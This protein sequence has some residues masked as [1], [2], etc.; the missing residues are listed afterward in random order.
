M[1][2]FTY[3][4]ASHSDCRPRAGWPRQQPWLLSTQAAGTAAGGLQSPGSR[5][6]KGA[7]GRQSVLTTDLGSP[8]ATSRVSCWLH[9]SEQKEVQACR[10]RGVDGTQ[11]CFCGQVGLRKRLASRLRQPTLV[12]AAH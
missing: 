9:K 6:S 1:R 5:G 2:G 4:Q 8:S 11:L 7:R 3:C 10:S 12:P